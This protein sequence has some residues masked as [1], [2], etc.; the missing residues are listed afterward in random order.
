MSDYFWIFLSIAVIMGVSLVIVAI[1]TKHK[2]TMKELEIQSMKLQ[3]AN[4]E[5][6]NKEAAK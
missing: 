1:V 5:A 6:G 4:S 3:K 2:Q